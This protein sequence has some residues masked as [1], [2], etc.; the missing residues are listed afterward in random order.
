MKSLY[1]F[2]LAASS[3]L[4]I[5]SLGTA[6]VLADSPG[7]LTGGPNT[8]VVKNV[9]KNGSYANSASATCNEEVKYS[10]RLHNAA[11]GGLT[12]IQAK[13]NLPAGSMTAVPAE[14]ASQGTSGSVSVTVAAGGTLVYE[15]GSTIL[16]DVNGGVIKTLPDTITSSG[17]NVGNLK[18]STTEFVNFMAKVNCP[19][20]P[21]KP[22]FSCKALNVTVSENRKVDASVTYTAKDGASLTNVGFNWG[23]NSSTN[24]GLATSASHTYAKDGTYNIVA[25]LT[26]N[27]AGANKADTCS[28]SVTF[29]TPQVLPATTTP[30][31]STGAGS[32]LGLF[33][34]V[35]ALGTAGH[36]V[37]RRYRS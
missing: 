33:A 24:A 37:F 28:K 4:A 18:G 10:I 13:V 11:F 16:Y 36:F 31:P 30:L 20:P 2:A 6:P 1:K 35:S 26:F 21:P 14:G 34:G 8:F 3:A 17:V 12:N 7:Q 23:D 22:I 19:T 32:V 15:N 5:A 29:T 27:V 25:T 9:T